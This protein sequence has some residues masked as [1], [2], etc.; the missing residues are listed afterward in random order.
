V[1]W[2]GCRWRSTVETR[3]RPYDFLW[4]PAHV[5]TFASNALALGPDILS[6]DTIAKAGLAVV[7]LIVFAEC[8]LMVGFFLPGDSLLFTV[9]LLISRD[10]VSTPLWL[11]CILIGFAAVAGD[12]TGYLIGRKVGPT[13]FRRPDSRLF[14]QENVD[15]AHQFFEKYGPRSIILARFVPVV[16]T[17]TPVIVGVSR[18]KYRVYLTY[19]MVGGLLW[20]CGVTV[21][22]YYLG[23]IKLVRD[24]VEAMLVLIVLVSVVPIAVEVYRGRR[25]KADSGSLPRSRPGGR[26]SVT[27]GGRRGPAAGA[28]DATGTGTAEKN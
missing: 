16:R 14:K 24:N 20:G 15:K 5:S 17:F 1:R 7:L 18:M 8:G 23:K 25:H 19:D 28:A 4:R 11:A 10:E 22:G 26:H 21:L 2:A 27:A 6:A 12:Q 13:L 3:R 9:G